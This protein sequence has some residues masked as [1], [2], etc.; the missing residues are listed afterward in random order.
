MRGGLGAGGMTGGA[1]NRA[2]IE[3]DFDQA[4]GDGAG[5]GTLTR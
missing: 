5:I 4:Q 3:E 2:L 1:E